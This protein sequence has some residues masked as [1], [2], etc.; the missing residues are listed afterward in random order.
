MEEAAF[1][2]DHETWRA[3]RRADLTRSGGFLLLVG[4]Y[5]LAKGTTPFGA[6]TSLSIAVPPG[7]APLL[8]GTLVREGTRVTLQPA[9][10]V[11]IS[12]ADSAAGNPP[13]TG[14][15][16]LRTDHDSA[17]PTDVALGTLRLRIHQVGERV[18]LRVWDEDHPLRRTFAG[19]ESYP[20]QLPW[21]VAARFRS[22]RSPRHVRVADVSGGQQDYDVPGELVFRVDGQER[23]LLPFAE[24]ADTALWI[25]FGDSTNARETYGAGRYLYVSRPDSSGWTVI[26][27]NRAYNPPCAFNAF[28]TC[29][30][31]PRENR[32]ALAVRA[33]EKRY[34]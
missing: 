4:L 2:R 16:A 14:P 29:P 15:L 21:R 18:W 30:L 8:A 27:F 20:A 28:A 1:R 19:A 23:R 33:G 26:D 5:E 6:D 34:H 7:K 13:V 10:R 12:V 32:L 9:A 11:R 24:P 31:P 22:F 17:G 3:W 25:L